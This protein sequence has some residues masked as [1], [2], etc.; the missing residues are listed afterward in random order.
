MAKQPDPDPVFRPQV[1]QALADLLDWNQRTRKSRARAWLVAEQLMKE[2]LAAEALERERQGLAAVLAREAEAAGVAD[3][4]FDDM[5]HDGWGESA[6]DDNN[7]G[8]EGQFFRLLMW[9]ES[10]DNIR[11]YIREAPKDDGEQED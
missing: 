11:G 1:W 8:F 7:G 3:D 5:L 4:H 10:P 9:G 2:Q 6:S